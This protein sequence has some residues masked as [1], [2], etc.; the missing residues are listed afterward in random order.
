MSQKMFLLC[1]LGAKL[2]TSK[3]LH[4]CYLDVPAAI[5]MQASMALLFTLQAR[6][7]Q[8]CS[9]P[10]PRCSSASPLFRLLDI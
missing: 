1:S 6:D 2:H 9:H 4:S 5:G 10:R 8:H 7:T 3:R